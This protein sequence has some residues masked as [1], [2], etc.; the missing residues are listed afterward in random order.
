[1]KHGCME[2]TRVELL[3]KIYDWVENGSQ[4]LYWLNGIAGTGKSAV[5]HTVAE[6]YAK[7]GR[8]GGSFFFSRDQEARSKADF[9]FHTLACQLANAF[10]HLK[11][12]IAAVLRDGSVPHTTRSVQF[13][14]LILGPI[15]GS[16]LSAPIV[17]VL[18]AL[19][20]CS[21]LNASKDIL[22]LLVHSFSQANQ[23]IPLK[24]FLTSRPDDIIQG[25]VQNGLRH[26]QVIVLHEVLHV[27]DDIKIYLEKSRK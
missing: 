16:S 15:K 26:T 11:A 21:D 8:L 24:V 6:Y 10:P 17:I 12:K 22:N 23:S 25:A 19:D 20:E 27:E 2:G 18:D 1:M 3:H 9:A 5:A 13:E 4:N 14:K 7:R